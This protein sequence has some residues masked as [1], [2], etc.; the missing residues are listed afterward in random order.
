MT[1]P[2]LNLPNSL[3]GH[4]LRGSFLV[5]GLRRRFSV[6]RGNKTGGRTVEHRP[7][8]VTPPAPSGAPAGAPFL[9]H[10]VRNWGRIDTNGQELVEI[11]DSEI[12]AG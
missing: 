8:L 12:E 9:G 11:F 7:A 3:V 5:G 2:T 1:A 10:L 4:H 6:Q